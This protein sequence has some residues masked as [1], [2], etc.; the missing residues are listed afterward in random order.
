MLCGN[1]YFVRDH[2]I[3]TKRVLRAVLKANDICAAEPEK[4]TQLLIDR[5]YTQQYDYVRQTLTELPYARWREF[6]AEDSMRF[7][8]CGSTK[9]T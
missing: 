1:Q 7:L 5:G 3:V 2:P 6:D 4:V 9:S 8:R